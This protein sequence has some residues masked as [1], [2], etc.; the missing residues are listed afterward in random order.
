MT[1]ESITTDITDSLTRQCAFVNEE[2]YG[3]DI[4]FVGSTSN[5][6]KAFSD[7][8]SSVSGEAK[9][10]RGW[11]RTST[12]E[13][14]EESE[15]Q[16][17][18]SALIKLGNE[19]FR[20][21][22]LSEALEAYDEAID[23][24]YSNE[25]GKRSTAVHMSKELKENQ[26][27]RFL[28]MAAHHN[29]AVINCI[30]YKYVEAFENFVQVLEMK[31]QTDDGLNVVLTV[32]NI[33]NNLIK[34]DELDCAM[35]LCLD[36]I[37]VLSRLCQAASVNDL[38]EFISLSTTSIANMVSTI[39]SCAMR[40][41]LNFSHGTL[42]WGNVYLFRTRLSYELVKLFFSSFVVSLSYIKLLLP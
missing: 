11:R 32:K 20:G 34:K 8:D 37:G 30:N 5:E 23:M 41:Y 12:K 6:T 18:F 33:I 1:L 13:R 7:D 15:P 2:S 21:N 38:F 25:E 17:M 9:L 26:E 10:Q 36:A 14:L 4:T 42:F 35:S 28:A 22:E 24:I 3:A 16:K 27:C 31:E 40:H 19:C 29:I 39:I